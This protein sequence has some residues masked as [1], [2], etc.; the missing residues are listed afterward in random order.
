[1]NLFPPKDNS[2]LLLVDFQTGFLKPFKEKV[3]KSIEDKLSLLIETCKFYKLPII[4]MEQNNDKLGYTTEKIQ[5]SLG[6]FYKPFNKFIFSG[7]RDAAVKNEIEKQKK[8]NIII[9]GIETHICVLQTTYDLISKNY[10]VY[11]ISDAVG[12]R[13]KED[14]KFG[15]DKLKDI[16]ANLLSTEM[17]LFGF[18]ERSDTKDFKHFL[19]FLK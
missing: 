3:V 14:Y 18:L 5:K 8:Q 12:S 11:I 15:L 6:D 19:P 13:F 7:M 1:M 17:L 10:N 9:A 4:V 2:L 16:G